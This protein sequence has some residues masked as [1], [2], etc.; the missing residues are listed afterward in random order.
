MV[1]H[2]PRGNRDVW[3]P[4]PGISW[5]S[6]DKRGKV[7]GRAALFIWTH[8]LPIVQNYAQI[9]HFKTHGVCLHSM[10]NSSHSS[11]PYWGKVD[12]PALSLLRKDLLQTHHSVPRK[13]I[14]SPQHQS[15]APWGRNPWPQEVSH[16]PGRGVPHRDSPSEDVQKISSFSSRTIREKERGDICWTSDIPFLSFR[17][18]FT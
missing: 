3:L 10:A 18:R 6:V 1:W 7:R 5:T 4:I 2:L 11:K 15:Y 12:P 8:F 13:T 14:P 16:L 9:G 17:L